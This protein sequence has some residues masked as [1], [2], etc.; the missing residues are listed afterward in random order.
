MQCVV[1][2]HSF[3]PVLVRGLEGFAVRQLSIAK[4]SVRSAGPLD[5]NDTVSYMTNVPHR[6]AKR[7]GFVRGVGHGCRRR[8]SCRYPVPGKAWGG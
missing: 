7:N 6:L 1:K 4:L 2:V 5:R 8:I 3:V